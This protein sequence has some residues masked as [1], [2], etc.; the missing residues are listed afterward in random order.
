VLLKPDLDRGNSVFDI[1][2]RL[3][4]NYVW[5]IPFFASRRDFVGALLRGWQLNGIWSF[6][7]GA[8]WSP[9]SLDPPVLQPR[10]GFPGACESATFDPAN[11][12]NI[13]GDFNLDGESNDRPNAIANNFHP[14]HSQWSN[15]FN[16]PANFFSA[17]CLGCVGNLGR[18]TFVGPRYWNADASIFR[19]FSLAD[20]FHL[21]FRAETF[22]VLNHANFLIGDN[23]SLHDPLFGSASGTAPPRNLQFGLKLSF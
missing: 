8:H 22:N 13:G 6:Q 4:F 3:A 9:F 19:N 21:Q 23:T 20:R 17:P 16:L 18:N 14:T 2:H 7:T 12:V 11:C 15:G 1:R 10:D 5:E